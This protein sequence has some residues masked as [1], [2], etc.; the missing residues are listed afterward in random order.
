MID[1]GCK[2]APRLDQVVTEV[3]GASFGKEYQRDLNTSL[4]LVSGWKTYSSRTGKVFRQ[5][6]RLL[7]GWKLANDDA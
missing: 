3:V 5:M 7:G 1:A 4:S 2:K 6:A